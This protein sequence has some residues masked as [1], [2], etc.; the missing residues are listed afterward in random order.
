MAGNYQRESANPYNGINALYNTRC[1]ILCDEVK[2]F[3]K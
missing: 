1:F 2:Y 3:N